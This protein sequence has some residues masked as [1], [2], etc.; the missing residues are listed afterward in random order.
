MCTDPP[1]FIAVIIHARTNMFINDDMCVCMCIYMLMR[2][3]TN[4][5]H[6]RHTNIYTHI[7][8]CKISCTF[9]LSYTHTHTHTHILNAHILSLSLS[10]S[11]ILNAHILSLSLSYTHTHTKCAHPCRIHTHIRTNMESRA[12]RIHAYINVHTHHI[13]RWT[14]PQ[15]TFDQCFQALLA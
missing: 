12:T 2:A 10:L 7:H 8:T 9:S 14:S 15:Q 6:K 1:A 4:H 5:T 11:Y 13:R 3:Y